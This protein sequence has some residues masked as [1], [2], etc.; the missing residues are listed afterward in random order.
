[1]IYGMSMVGHRP[2]LT[3]D[4]DGKLTTKWETY[5]VPIRVELPAKPADPRFAD[6]GVMTWLRQVRRAL[7]IRCEIM[8][9]GQMATKSMVE[10]RLMAEIGITHQDA[11]QIM[12]V[13][14]YRNLQRP[15]DV[16]KSYK[17]EV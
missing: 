2:K 1:M 4:A 8:D 3:V 13:I 9:A 16:A 5:T 10:A 14:E 17:I 12:N 15:E 7:E 6:E 11:H